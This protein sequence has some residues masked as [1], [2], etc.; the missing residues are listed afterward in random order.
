M[1]L[2]KLQVQNFKNIENLE[3]DFSAKLNC[4]VGKNGVGK[5]NLLDAIYYLSY[6]KSH[7]N[8][9]DDL[10]IRHGEAYFNINSS[11][12][13][14]GS[15]EA[16]FTAYSNDKKK[17]FKRNDKKYDKLADHIG[18]LP[19]IFIT[20]SDI[21]LI[22]GSGAERRRFIDS[23]ISQLDGEYLHSLMYYNRVLMQRNK[24][25]KELKSLALDNGML[26]AFD[27]QLNEHG[28]IVQR[29][30][31]RVIEELKP[32]FTSFYSSISSNSESVDI[33]YSTSLG[34][35]NILTSLENS[36]ERDFILQHTTTGI[37]RDDIDFLLNKHPVRHLGSQGQK[38]SFLLALKFA[39]YDYMSK[40]KQQKPLLLLDD[41]FDKLDPSRVERIVEIV[42]T[43]EFGQIFITDTDKDTV[44]TIY[45]RFEDKEGKLFDFTNLL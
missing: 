1:H 45:D 19:L 18:L 39:Q 15:L 33:N 5:T 9:N 21:T 8:L 10:L 23:F 43:H 3:L 28:S 35:V 27:Y 37:H 2:Q 16:V 24:Y 11:F 13:I 4:I 14:K 7:F 32:I 31:E 38:K 34:G 25:L 42:S 36:R 44:L 12:H 26:E 17:I 41:L 20:P 22:N 40:K 29:K 30:R 6:C